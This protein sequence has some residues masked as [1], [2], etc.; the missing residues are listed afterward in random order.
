M[1]QALVR[2]G[3]VR[4]VL[5]VL[6]LDM[7]GDRDLSVTLPENASPAL[8]AA[9]FEAARQEGIRE[10]FRLAGD[11]LDDHTAFLEAGIPAAD[12]I[13]FEYGSKPG[14][15][16]YWHTAEDRIDKLSAESLRDVGRVV[17]RVINGWPAR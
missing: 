8:N 14:R 2:E 11:I 4:D 17:L 16:D 7:I 5:G 13:D 1:A 12:I 6:V 15:N 10:K 9:I 3:R